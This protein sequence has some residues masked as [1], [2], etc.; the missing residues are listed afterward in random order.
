[1]IC[2]R[3]QTPCPHPVFFLPDLSS[4]PKPFMDIWPAA[5]VNEH[6]EQR[7]KAGGRQRSGE[8]DTLPTPT[9]QRKQ[10][11]TME[12]PLLLCQRSAWVSKRLWKC[13]Q[14]DPGTHTSCWH[15]QPEHFW[16]VVPLFLG[17]KR[18]SHVCLCSEKTPPVPPKSALVQ[19]CGSRLSILANIPSCGWPRAAA[20]WQSSTTGWAR[21]RTMC[22]V[23]G[24]HLTP[25][26]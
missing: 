26:T 19:T 4:A 12:C 6:S 15:R 18:S 21:G 10:Q 22:R 2:P 8:R 3:F 13:Q 1:M 23:V 25:V 16:Q 7:A 11:S 14:P 24:K 9:P 20:S 5:T 17:S